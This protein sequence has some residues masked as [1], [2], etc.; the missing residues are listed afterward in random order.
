MPTV[1]LVIFDIGGTII[2][3]NGEVIE[4]FSAALEQNGL[5]ATRQKLTELKGASK[6]DVITRFVERG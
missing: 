1:K 4:A 5:H 2:Q 3:D 6:R